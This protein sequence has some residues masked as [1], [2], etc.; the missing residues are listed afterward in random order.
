MPEEILEALAIRGSW[1]YAADFAAGKVLRFDLRYGASSITTFATVPGVFGIFAAGQDDLFVTSNAGFTGRENGAGSN[2][3]KHLTGRSVSTVAAG[4]LYPEGIGGDE[5]YLYVGAGAEVFTVPV[6]GGTPSFYSSNPL[7]HQ[8][9][10]WKGAGY[11]TNSM[12]PHGEV[13]KFT[14]RR[15][16]M[17]K[18]Q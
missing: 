13:L 12:P 4:L 18:M 17:A 8:I 15:K 7:G 11:V 5:E 2:D 14:L 1:L 16:E 10:I 3:V 9:N 6:A